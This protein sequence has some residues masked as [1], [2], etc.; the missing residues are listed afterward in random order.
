MALMGVIVI[1]VSVWAVR[2]LTA[3]L[4]VLSAA[5]DRL[6]RDVRPS[7]WPKAAPSRCRVPPAPST[8]CRSG[9]AG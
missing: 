3:P 4:G 1:A 9:C 8:A 2:R 6:G 7:R 5:A